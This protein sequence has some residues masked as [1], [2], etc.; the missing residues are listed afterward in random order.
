VT[1]R[2]LTRHE[3]FTQLPGTLEAADERYRFFKSAATLLAFL[4]ALPASSSTV[5]GPR[6]CPGRR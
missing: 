5:R 3:L 2:V 1:A 6:R 4:D